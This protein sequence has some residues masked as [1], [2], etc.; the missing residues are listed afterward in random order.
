MSWRWRSARSVDAVGRN[1][2]PDRYSLPHGEDVVEVAQ[3]DQLTVSRRGAT[4]WST[5]VGRNASDHGAAV[6]A[7]DSVY[8]AHFHAIATGASVA[9]LSLVDG[10]VAWDRPLFGAGPIGH[11]KYANNV[12]VE[13][14]G[15]HLHIFGRE[16]GGAY[17]EVVDLATGEQ[18]AHRPAPAD[19]VALRWK[20]TGDRDEWAFPD[21]PIGVPGYGE[22]KLVGGRAELPG[23]ATV[24]LS[25]HEGSMPT[26]AALLRDD[27]LF[28]AQG[29]A[30]SSG[31]TLHAVSRGSGDILWT[32]PLYGIGPTAHSEYFNALQIAEHHGVIVVYGNEANGRYLEAVDPATGESLVSKRW[33]P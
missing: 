7:G 13:V 5:A 15:D 17:T 27:V 11:S 6:I 26:G 10:S 12:Q 28:I 21:G 16:S 3:G 24:R 18:I 1:W 20:W 31:A 22:V 23:G 32:R 4:R 9:K 30:A 8:V 19:L 14:V 29:S 2:G 25:D 33:L